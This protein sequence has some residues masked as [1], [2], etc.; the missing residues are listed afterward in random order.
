MYM[1]ISTSTLGVCGTLPQ[2]IVVFRLSKTA[3]G[4]FS[5]TVSLAF[6]KRF[7]EKLFS[8]DAVETGIERLNV[9][10]SKGA[11]F[12]QGGKCPLD[13]SK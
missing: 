10:I 7:W 5:G 9:A 3:F 11:R 4:A 1:C 2:E 8:T 12:D 13:P 6:I